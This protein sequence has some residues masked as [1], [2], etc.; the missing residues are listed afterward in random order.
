MWVCVASLAGSQPLQHGTMPLSKV[1]SF[2]AVQPW[3]KR[4]NTKYL[5]FKYYNNKQ[6]LQ[7]LGLTPFLTF[8]CPKNL[9]LSTALHSDLCL[10]FCL[11]R[12]HLTLKL[13]RERESCHVSSICNRLEHSFDFAQGPL[14]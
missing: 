7:V 4:P 3:Y 12:L 9:S 8:T 1:E 2:S 10:E 6:T 5:R 14:Y 13:I 11:F